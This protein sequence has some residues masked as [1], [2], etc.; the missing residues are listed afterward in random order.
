MAHSDDDL[1]PFGIILYNWKRAIPA[2]PVILRGR[3]AMLQYIPCVPSVHES[4]LTVP[5]AARGPR[6]VG[7]GALLIAVQ[8]ERY[9]ETPRCKR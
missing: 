5:S 3:K 9:M 7:Q 2:S 6:Q 1:T 4:G 8:T